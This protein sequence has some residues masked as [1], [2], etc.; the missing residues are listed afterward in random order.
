MSLAVDSSALWAVIKGERMSE[1]WLALLNEVARRTHLVICDVVVAETAPFFD[2]VA[3]LRS[4]LEALHIEFSPVDPESAFLA[5]EIFA[6]Y[7]KLGG[8]RT[9]L[10]PDFLIGAHA[11]KQ[12]TGLLTS[13]RG[14]LRT[15]F[16]SL[17]IYKPAEG[18]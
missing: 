1:E 17:K 4:V 9:S 13:D 10:I 11:I 12:A 15:Y 3:S 16:Q 7:R 14:Y 2:N 8:K 6:R 5:G 18:R